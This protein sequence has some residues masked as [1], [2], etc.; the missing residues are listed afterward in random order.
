MMIHG[1][2]EEF[3]GKELRFGELRL[4]EV[5]LFWKEVL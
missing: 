5:F 3:A 2:E 1:V 4:S